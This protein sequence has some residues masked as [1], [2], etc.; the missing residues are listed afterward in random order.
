MNK[1]NYSQ[2]IIDRFWSKV[3]YPGNDQNCREW[4]TGKTKKGYGQ[5]WL[6][7]KNVEAHRFAWEFYNG[8]IPN[9]LLVCHKCDNPPCCNPEHLFLGTFLDNNRDTIDKGKFIPSQVG[10]NHYK[11]KLNNKIIEKVLL[12]I[13]SGEIS[14]ISDAS[15]SLGVKYHVFSDI[16]NGKNWKHITDKYD[17]TTIKSMLIKEN[18][19]SENILDI[20]HR[21]KM[22]ETV[23]AISQLYSTTIQTI[24]MIKTGKLHSNITGNLSNQDILDIK[25]IKDSYIKLDENKVKIIKNLLKTQKITKI[26]KMFNVATG[27]IR[28]INN[29]ITWKHVTI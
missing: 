23:K 26:A 18:L 15:E 14:N 27:T 5:F 8:L 13:Q 11:T 4:T 12:K 2:D 16:L 25:N 9:G 3:N 29:G 19:S 21:L 6:N 17:L 1:M 7:R 10:E 20:K 22:G 28:S 24:Y